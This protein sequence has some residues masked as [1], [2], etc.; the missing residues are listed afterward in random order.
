MKP[1]KFLP[2]IFP[3]NV[4]DYLV[5]L[6]VITGIIC[7]FISLYFKPPKNQY[8]RFV[9]ETQE[10]ENENCQPALNTDEMTGWCK[11]RVIL[12]NTDISVERNK[13]ESISVFGGKGFVQF[14]PNEPCQPAQNL[15]EEICWKKCLVIIMDDELIIVHE[16]ETL[17]SLEETPTDQGQEEIQS[18]KTIE[19]QRN[20]KTNN[21]KAD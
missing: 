2:K 19:F 6:G 15:E 8:V 10:F 18:P 5:I 4:N 17:P 9:I 3:I 14:Y 16:N 12:E 21:T 11:C 1:N 13:C 7:L 20:F